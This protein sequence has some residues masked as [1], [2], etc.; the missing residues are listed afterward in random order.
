MIIIDTTVWIDYLNGTQTLQTDWLDAEITRQR[1][2]LTDH[3]LRNSARDE[4]R[5]T[6]NGDP[7]GTNEISSDANGWN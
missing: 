1:L 3:S 4:G 2:G 7:A 6:G 5:R